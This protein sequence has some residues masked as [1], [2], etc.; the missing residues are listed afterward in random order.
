[1]NII[2]WILD[3]VL[4]F[5]QDDDHQHPSHVDVY[6]IQFI[7]DDVD[8]Y[9]PNV[10]N[11]CIQVYIRYMILENIIC[12]PYTRMLVRSSIRCTLHLWGRMNLHIPCSHSIPSINR[13]KFY[14]MKHQEG[15]G[16]EGFEYI[17]IRIEKFA[18]HNK[19]FSR[20]RDT[21]CLHAHPT[22]CE[23]T[24]CFIHTLIM[25]PMRWRPVSVSFPAY[26]SACIVSIRIRCSL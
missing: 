1:M 16:G 14:E 26:N 8:D 19:S 22:P 18:W 17:F 4:L 10:T 25:L 12:I 6:F 13:L 7:L 20:D 24:Q 23:T 15:G 3:V 2:F 5:I 11:V 9:L 21:T